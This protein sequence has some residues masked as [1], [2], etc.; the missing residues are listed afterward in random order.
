MPHVVV[1]TVSFW[2]SMTRL[3]PKSAIS[4]SAS[5]SGPRKSRFWHVSALEQRVSHLWLEIAV[6][7]T[8]VVEIYAV[9]YNREARAYTRRPT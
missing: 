7:D 4:R 2:S 9:S 3:S 8:L 6:D 5:S 1:K